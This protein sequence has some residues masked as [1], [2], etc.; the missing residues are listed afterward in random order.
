MILYEHHGEVKEEDWKWPNFV[1]L[2][3]ACRGSGE[4]I[5]VPFAMD[6]LQRLR[7]FARR[8]LHINSAYRSRWYNVRIGG[9]D[10]SAHCALAPNVMAFD[11]SLRNLSEKS[12][13]PL[14][15]KA[16][17]AVQRPYDTFVH[18]DTGEERTW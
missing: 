14:I 13:L 5:V 8:P 15:R 10:Y 12:F 17:F 7:D 4:L 18:V 11:I 9:A 2:E 1:P 6:C 16:G 3:I